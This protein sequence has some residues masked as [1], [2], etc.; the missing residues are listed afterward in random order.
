MISKASLSILVTAAFVA[1]ILA[2]S[3]ALAQTPAYNS[4]TLGAIGDGTNAAGTIDGMAGPLAEPD[5]QAVL[6]PN[7]S[8]GG[9]GTFNTQ[10]PYLAELNPAGAFTI[11]FWVQTSVD[12]GGVGFTPVFNR[13]STSPRSGWVF[14]QRPSGEGWNFAMYDGNGSNVGVSVTGGTSYAGD[15]SHMVVVW[16]GGTT[17]S[18]YFNG[19]L[20]GSASGGFVPNVSG[21]MTIATYDNGENS[22]NGLV[23]EF[24]FYDYAL[25]PDRIQEH[26]NAASDSQVGG[27]SGLVL[28]DA[29]LE[30]L[31]VGK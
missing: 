17:A 14:Y 22:F 7:P 4:G 27:Y 28:I 21:I 11:E 5:D 24:A 8:P 30:Y 9:T 12:A 25:T 16:D 10:I 1:A 23:D 6:Y 18:M 20:V 15:W 2:P 31:Q 13:T 3:I 19:S 26:F 29:P